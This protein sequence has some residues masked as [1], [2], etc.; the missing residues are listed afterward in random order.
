MNA[1]KRRS[2]IYNQILKKGAAEVKDLACDFAC[3]TQ[4]I[5]R[6]LQELA[7][8]N[9]VSVSYGGAELKNRESTELHFSY[10]ETQQ[11]QF[12]ERICQKAASLV[13]DG[14]VVAIDTGTT[15]SALFKYLLDKKITIITNNLPPLSSIDYRCKAQ[16]IVAG[17]VYDAVSAGTMGSLATEFFH[18]YSVDIAF[19]TTMGL[20]YNGAISV[21]K[22]ED[23]AV[24][25]AIFNA[26]NKKVLLVDENKFGLSFLCHYQNVSDFDLL[27][28][29]SD[30]LPEF[31]SAFK[32][33]YL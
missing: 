19:L 16:I 5:R 28:S 10:K 15:T 29:N 33:D 18:Q 3:S 23:A 17:G 6:D 8:Q 20:D 9:L 7:R 11:I 25:R 12:K 22:P 31:L 27:V 32:L 26:A 4:T 14:A 13:K 24:K 2:E 21:V 30:E 1:I